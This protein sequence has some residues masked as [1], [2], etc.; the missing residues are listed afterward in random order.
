VETVFIAWIGCVVV[1]LLLA[2]RRLQAPPVTPVALRRKK[3]SQN[4]SRH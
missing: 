4:L 1:A 3:A 2:V